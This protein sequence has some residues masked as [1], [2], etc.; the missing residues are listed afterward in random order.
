MASASSDVEDNAFYWYF[1]VARL[2]AALS[3]DLLGAAMVSRF[4]KPYRGAWAG[5][6]AGPG[7]WALSTQANY[8]LDALDL[9][10]QDQSRAGRWH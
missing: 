2:A 4:A 7:A 1:V 6:L 9:R 3:P 8:A 5:V 10:P